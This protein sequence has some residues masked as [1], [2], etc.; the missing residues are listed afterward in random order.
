MIEAAGLKIHKIE[1]DQG[2]IR[3]KMRKQVLDKTFPAKSVSPFLV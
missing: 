1:E 2:E 3:I